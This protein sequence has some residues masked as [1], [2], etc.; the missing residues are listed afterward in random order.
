M[1]PVS[2]INER[3]EKIEKKYDIITFTSGCSPSYFAESF[4]PLVKER[5]DF[6]SS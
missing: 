1:L 3:V 4:C 6:T 2:I 5:Y